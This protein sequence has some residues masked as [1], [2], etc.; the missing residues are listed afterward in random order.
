MEYLRKI[1]SVIDRAKIL[2]V[3]ELS[4]G[5]KLVGH[6]PHV[7]PEAWLHE[8]FGPLVEQDVLKLENEMRRPIPSE[9]RQFLKEINGLM[10]FSCSLSIYGF[11]TS[12]SRSGDEVWQPFSLVTPNTIERP[13]DALESFFFFGGYGWDGSRLYI[14]TATSKVIRAARRTSKPLSEWNSFEEMLVTETIRIALLFDN[15]GRQLDVNK[16]T[17]P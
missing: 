11:R 1:F 5:G 8:V 4:N 14:D 6:V 15:S 3:R 12:F 10:L 13:K 9:I 2:G 16:P 7:A 17:T